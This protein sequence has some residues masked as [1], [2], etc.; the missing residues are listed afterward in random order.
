VWPPPSG[1]PH[2]GGPHARPTKAADQV[3]TTANSR[4]RVDRGCVE[5][6]VG[7]RIEDD[8]LKGSWKKFQV[9]RRHVADNNINADAS[10]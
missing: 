5:W 8:E 1:E 6:G 9:D 4:A 7:Q 2:L 3:A 10:P